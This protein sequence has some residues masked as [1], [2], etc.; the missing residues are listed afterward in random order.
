M[1][2]FD[3]TKYM[4]KIAPVSL[5]MDWDNPGLIIGD[6]ERKLESVV[7]CL[8]VT[9]DVVDFAIENRANLILSHHPFIFNGIK[10]I[11]TKSYKGTLIEKIIKNDICVYAAH[12]N[13]DFAPNGLNNQLARKLDLRYDNSLFLG[14]DKERIVG[15]IGETIGTLKFSDFVENLKNKL[16]VSTVRTVGNLDR[17]I[18]KVAVFCGA[19]DYS[20]LKIVAKRVD[21]IVT[22]DLK[23]HVA[24]DILESG[25]NAVDAGHFGTEYIFVECVKKL[26][27]QEFSEIKVL[28]LDNEKDLLVCM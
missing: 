6:A 27:E 16:N 8:D 18:N 7:V 19:F 12:T 14:S 15:K 2:V 4:E 22:G 23:Y 28:T 3:I 26:L 10:S 11:N 24:M 21:C 13:F 5:A 20:F 25:L 1:N 17:V 9:K